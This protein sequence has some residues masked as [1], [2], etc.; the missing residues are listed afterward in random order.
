MASRSPIN[1]LPF[2]IISHIFYIALPLHHQV[3]HWK[4]NHWTSLSRQ[5]SRVLRLVMSICRH[6]TFIAK[7]SPRLWTLVYWDG[8]G[9]TQTFAG[10]IK[11]IE[12]QLGLSKALPISLI[13]KCGLQTQS[14]AQSL[15]KH[16]RAFKRLVTK[17][18]KR[19][20]YLYWSHR[21]IEL[22]PSNA[23]WNT[24]KSLFY[25]KGPWDLPTFLHSPP[26]LSSL[27]I[28]A[29]SSSGLLFQPLNAV[30]LN[31]SCLRRL[32]LRYVDDRRWTPLLAQC[33]QL[34]ELALWDCITMEPN[35]HIH[36]LSVQ[37][38]TSGNIANYP[39]A[40][41]VVHLHLNIPFPLASG[42]PLFPLL[43]SLHIT[44]RGRIRTPPADGYPSNVLLRAPNLQAFSHYVYASSKGITAVLEAIRMTLPSA[45]AANY[46]KTSMKTSLGPPPPPP[47]TSFNPLCYLCLFFAIGFTDTLLP[48]E[49]SRASATLKTLLDQRPNMHIDLIFVE[50]DNRDLWRDGNIIPSFTEIASQW[51]DRLSVRRGDA[52]DRARIKAYDVSPWFLRDEMKEN[53]NASRVYAQDVE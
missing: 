5:T 20:V 23:R 47:P 50:Y 25:I 11:V 7:N 15:P 18:S 14:E 51:T 4:S 28:D 35:T 1:E 42:F 30:A 38:C 17:H 36:S 52:G 44:G 46:A 41:T 16:V 31:F 34:E 49:F 3:E 22:W 21:D 24:L 10:S 9:R 39:Y 45:P 6:W 2:E 13:V 37:H 48:E 32:T 26:L 19:V 43:E 53:S 29:S 40:S 8:P 27:Y 12:T 33:N